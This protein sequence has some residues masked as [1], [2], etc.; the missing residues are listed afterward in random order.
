M[1]NQ[2]PQYGDPQYGSQPY[3]SNPPYGQPPAPEQPSY[4]QPPVSGGSPYGQPPTTGSPYGQPPAPTAPTYGQPPAPTAPTYGQP[5]Y[6]Q[7]QPPTYG[8]PPEP[9]T[10]GQP[11]QPPTYGQPP[12]QPTYGAPAQPQPPAY[13]QPPQPYGTSTQATQAFGTAPNPYGQPQYS[14][15]PMGYQPPPPPAKSNT[16]MWV[17][18][19][20]VVVLLIG[21]GAAAFILINKGKSTPTASGSHSAGTNSPGTNPTTPGG[22]TG[23]QTEE[24]RTAKISTPDK[25]AGLVLSTDSDKVSAAN[26]TR[27]SFK[28]EIPGYKDILGAFYD[29]PEDSTKL[30]LVVAATADVDDPSNQLDT[31]FNDPSATITNVHTV[32][33]GTMSGQGE[34]ANAETGGNAAIVCAWADH[35]S[36]GVVFFFSRTESEAESLFVQFRNAI[37]TRD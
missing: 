26:Q 37:L 18:I 16:G 21:G 12:Q 31:I 15:P 22:G 5:S 35:G 25:V 10:Y 24:E 30:V 3:G 11:P 6:G 20:I 29:D 33:V 13:G 9:P 34:C 14:A 1:S 28:G 17:A 23:S 7:P 32:D 4:G 36:V 8:A 2:G 27:D 19:A